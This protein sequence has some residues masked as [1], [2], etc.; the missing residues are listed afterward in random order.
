MGTVAWGTPGMLCHI[1]VAFEA[2]KVA[3]VV[4]STLR[5]R[6]GMCLPACVLFAQGGYHCRNSHVCAAQDP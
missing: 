6:V 5:V 2:Y 1:Y 4:S 3:G